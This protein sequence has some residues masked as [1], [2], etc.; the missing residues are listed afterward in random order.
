MRSRNK[1]SGS[2]KHPTMTW[3]TP[4]AP[5]WPCSWVRSKPL[6]SA[7][8]RTWHRE[9][10]MAGLLDGMLSLAMPDVT[11]GGTVVGA[12]AD[13]MAGV[14]ALDESAHDYQRAD[15]YYTGQVPE[16]FASLRMRRA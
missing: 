3:S 15:A 13:L 5:L 11:G 10:R 14:A 9:T 1:W 16:F 7:Q 2:R 4:W 12:Q 6:G 8:R